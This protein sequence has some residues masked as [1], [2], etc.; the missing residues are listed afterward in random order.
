MKTKLPA[1]NAADRLKGSPTPARGMGSPAGAG[2][3]EIKVEGYLDECWSDWLGGL[4]VT[5]D[6]QGCT[7][8]VG[9][10]ADQ[11]ALHGILAQIR[12]LGLT[13]ISLTP[14][15]SGDGGKAGMDE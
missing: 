12:D 11:A 13:L 1:A 14:K 2:R 6:G 5:H 3:Y 10:I 4:T 15:S 7:L 8:L 9:A